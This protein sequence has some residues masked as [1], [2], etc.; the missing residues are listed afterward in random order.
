MLNFPCPFVL[1]I[2]VKTDSKL[3]T[4]LHMRKTF[5][6]EFKIWRVIFLKMFFFFFFFFF[7]FGGVCGGG[8]RGR[9][10]TI[11]SLFCDIT[12]SIFFI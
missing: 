2:A 3:T 4:L 10:L 9:R 1:F 5:I 12:K 7:F 11:K 8:G 6:I